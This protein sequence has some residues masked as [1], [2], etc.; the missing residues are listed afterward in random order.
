MIWRAKNLKFGDIVSYPEISDIYP[1]M[2]HDMMLAD[3]WQEV[4]DASIQWQHKQD[5]LGRDL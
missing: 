1:K 3:R 5:L 4:A 2:A